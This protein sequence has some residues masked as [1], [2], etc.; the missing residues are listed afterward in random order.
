LKTFP[1]LPESDDL[2]ELKK[3]NA[4]V[5]T[6]RPPKESPEWHAQRA[7]TLCVSELA[8]IMGM[9]NDSEHTRNKILRAK[10]GEYVFKYNEFGLKAMAAGKE[11]EPIALE[12]A[13][14]LFPWTPFV[15]FG[16]L[17]HKRWPLLQGEPDGLG[18][19]PITGRWMP[20]EIKTR[21][22]PSIEEAVP[23]QSVLDIPLKHVIQCQAYSEL[24]DA[25]WSILFSFSR[26][27]G[28]K[29]YYIPRDKYFWENWVETILAQFELDILPPQVRNK[30]PLRCYLEEFLNTKVIPL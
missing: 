30:E 28:Y 2:R 9:D 11:F 27:H 20:I 1:G 3:S 19:N 5:L 10:R 16:S 23:Y 7:K 29:A 6:E 22:W 14:Q 12:W 13:K 24:V 26:N 8:G 21:C 25:D 15:K 4:V 18:I 17:R